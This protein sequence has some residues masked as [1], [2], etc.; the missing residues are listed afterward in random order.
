MKK[1]MLPQIHFSYQNISFSSI[2]EL[3]KSGIW[4]TVNQGGHIL[5][6]GCDLLLANWFINPISM[7]VLAV[8]KTIPSLIIN[9]ASTL[10]SNVSPFITIMWAKGD[11]KTMLKELRSSMKV[12][13]ILVSTPIITF[14]CLGED[15]Y[16]LWMPTLDAKELTVLSFLACMPFIPMAGPQT[17][18]NVFT[19]TNHLQVNSVSFIITGIFNF[20]IVYVILSSGYEKGIYAIAGISAI[21]TIIRNMIVT[22]PYT[23]KILHLKWYEF[24]KDVL[25]SLSY[26]LVN[27][28]IAS[29][30]KAIFIPA[31]WASLLYTFFSVILITI[32]VE[33]FMTMTSSERK[34]MFSK[35]LRIKR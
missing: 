28:M 35:V 8:S 26:C 33:M 29:L 21:L 24:Y 16:Q 22:I 7:G 19:A 32:M 1:K 6:T 11:K 3:L 23:A 30:V 27:Y 17:L 34:M 5:M 13:C 4:N 25:V 15:F 18:Y 14:C 31:D 2:K 20:L 9:L 12:S 10:N